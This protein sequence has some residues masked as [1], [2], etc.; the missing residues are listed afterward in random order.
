MNVLGISISRKTTLLP[1]MLMFAFLLVAQGTRPPQL[2]KIAKPR[3]HHRDIVQ[4][5]EKASQTGV[6]KNVQ[7]LAFCPRAELVE[8]PA[9]HI[10]VFPSEKQT[11]TSVTIPSIPA[12]APPVSLI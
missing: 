5:Q 8:P 12:R 11:S 3:I 7:A 1:V 6:E 10:T 4:S 2:Q 9:Y